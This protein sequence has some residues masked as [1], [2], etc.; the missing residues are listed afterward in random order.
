MPF[1]IMFV[2]FESAL[3]CI[4]GIQLLFVSF[5][6]P[7]CLLLPSLSNQPILNIRS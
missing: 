5:L 7:F 6:F 1:L 4:Y 2:N 3:A